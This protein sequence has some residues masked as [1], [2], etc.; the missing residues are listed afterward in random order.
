MILKS[1]SN[2][3]DKIMNFKK[4]SLYALSISWPLNQNQHSFS[5]FLLIFSEEKQRKRREEKKRVK[6]D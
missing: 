2:K 4:N 3:K 1:Q 5:N 6:K